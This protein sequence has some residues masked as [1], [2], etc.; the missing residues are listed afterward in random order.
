MLGELLAE[1]GMDV[2]L[3]VS[4]LPSY[5][6]EMRSGTS[7]C[8][9]RISTDPIDSPLVSRPNVLLALNEPSLHKFLASV[10]AGGWVLYNSTEAPALA[11]R[12]DLTFLAMP[13]TSLADRLGDVRVANAVMLG[14]LLCVTGMLCPESIDSVL[15]R[16]V[17]SDRWLELNR[18][19]VANGR[20]V[21]LEGGCDGNR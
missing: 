9:V 15:Q 10:E 18:R 2:G 7:N 3:E 13:F 6:P 17:K 1:A 14:A 21:A 11:F 19:A 16:K 20:E 5:G 8:Q 12:D 4:W